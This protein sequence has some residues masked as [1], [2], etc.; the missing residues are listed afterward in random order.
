M[1]AQKNKT[2]DTAI[3]NAIVT[4]CEA[5]VFIDKYAFIRFIITD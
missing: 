5:L 3:I 4:F 2:V 1:P